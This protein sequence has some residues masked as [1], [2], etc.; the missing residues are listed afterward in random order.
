LLHG[1]RGQAAGDIDR[2]V[3]QVSESL[4]A[5]NAQLSAAS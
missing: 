5:V 3:R 4:R 1:A 2:L